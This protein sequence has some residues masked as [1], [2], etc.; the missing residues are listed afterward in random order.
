MDPATTELLLGITATLATI[1]LG[2]LR[3]ALAKKG[4]SEDQATMI[5]DYAEESLV[6]LRKALPDNKEVALGL[7]HV[8]KLRKLWD[9]ERVT[10]EDIRD[11]IDDLK[12]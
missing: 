4:V 10:T 9:D 7:K 11:Y 3:S 1:G 12:G 6:A 8:R 2:W 5:L